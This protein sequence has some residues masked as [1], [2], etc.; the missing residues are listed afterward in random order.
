MSAPP[1]SVDVGGDGPPSS[2]DLGDGYG[3]DYGGGEGSTSSAYWEARFGGESDFDP[4][5]FIPSYTRADKGERGEIQGCGHI[6]M[7]AVGRGV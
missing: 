7:G 6:G 1:S 5:A 2:V 4:S 3:A